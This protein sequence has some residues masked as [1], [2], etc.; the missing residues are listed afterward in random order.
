MRIDKQ[1]LL[2]GVL[3]GA[4]LCAILGS[5][6]QILMGVLAIVMLVGVIMEAFHR[7]I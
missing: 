5:A 6:N 2:L 4:T 3:V 7:R 1:S